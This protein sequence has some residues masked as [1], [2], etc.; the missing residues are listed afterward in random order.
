MNEY[1]DMAKIIKLQEL[2]PLARANMLSLIVFKEKTDKAGN[3]YLRH[4]NKVADSFEEN[5]AKIIALLH[6]LVEDTNFTF[7]DLEELNFSTS[8]ISS[9]RL[10]TNDCKN[11]DSYIERLIKSE[12]ILAK[13]VKIADL[14]DNMNINRLQEITKDDINRVKTKYLKA[15][16]MLIEDLEK[17]I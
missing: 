7:E 6:D 10:L 1:L 12:D 4:L 3:I 9:L 5:D 17:R 13:R 8:I 15:Y 11:Y 2:E 16:T 14:L